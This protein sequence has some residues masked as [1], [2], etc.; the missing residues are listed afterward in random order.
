MIQCCGVELH[1]LHVLH[2]SLGTIDHGNAVACSHQGVGGGVINQA[3]ATRR[4]ER[5]ARQ[6]SVHLA[7]F[8]IEDVCTIALDAR[9][10]TCHDFTQVVLSE[11]LD[12]KMVLIDVD[13]GIGADGLDKRRLYL[14]AGIVGMMQDAELAVSALAMQVELTF[15]IPVEVHTPTEQ[16]LNLGRSLGHDFLD[17]LGVAEPVA[18]HHRV[19]DVFLEVIYLKVGHCGDTALCQVGV[20]L[21]HLGLAHQGHGSR[22]CHFQGKTHSGHT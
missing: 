5:H 10:A 17:G 11:N 1:E 13:V 3:H 20:G 7:G 8:L 21:F 22:I 4:H 9:R 16:F 12:G 19:V 2:R 15:L 6:E 14:V 18:G